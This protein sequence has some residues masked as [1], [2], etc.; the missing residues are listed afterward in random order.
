M[1]R[2]YK[3]M[4]LNAL[5]NLEEDEIPLK[6]LYGLFSDAGSKTDKDVLNEVLENGIEWHTQGRSLYRFRDDELILFA[7]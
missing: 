5:V 3:E 7:A 4:F 1:L 2:Q 6:A